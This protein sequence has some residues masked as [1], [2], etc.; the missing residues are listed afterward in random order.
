MTKER[1]VGLALIASDS[2]LI[3]AAQFEILDT[4]RSHAAPYLQ[5]SILHRKQ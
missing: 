2:D 4:L 5:N 1:A 3:T